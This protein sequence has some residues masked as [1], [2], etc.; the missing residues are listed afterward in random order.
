[1]LPEILP[2][3]EFPFP[4]RM[5]VC[6]S[7][8]M[9]QPYRRCLNAL[10]SNWAWGLSLIALSLGMHA[11]GLV[12]IGL[13]L[14]RIEN[15]LGAQSLRRAGE[16][17]GAAL[18]IG[19]AGLMLAILGARSTRLLAPLTFILTQSFRYRLEVPLAS[20]CSSTGR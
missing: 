11:V 7:G 19:M 5:A 3:S 20:I 1:M 12:G 15:R 9:H 8:T 10:T 17:A 2:L 18:I 13:I 16:L 6:Q 14:A 4:K